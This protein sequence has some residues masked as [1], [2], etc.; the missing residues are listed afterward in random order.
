MA[1]AM[2]GPCGSDRPRSGAISERLHGG[3][4]ENN[5]QADVCLQNRTG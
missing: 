3:R 2:R 5:R 1:A 4:Q